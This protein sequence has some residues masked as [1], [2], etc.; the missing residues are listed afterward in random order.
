MTEGDH[1]VLIGS[2][3]ITAAFSMAAI[4]GDDADREEIGSLFIE[5]AEMMPSNKKTHVE[6]KEESFYKRALQ[7]AF[8]NVDDQDRA[9]PVVVGS[10]IIEAIKSLEDNSPVAPEQPLAPDTNSDEVR[11]LFLSKVVQ[12]GAKNPQIMK[13][14][15]DAF[16]NAK[17][18]SDDRSVNSSGSLQY[19]SDDSMELPFQEIDLPPQENV[20]EPSVVKTPAEDTPPFSNNHRNSQG[21]ISQD[22]SFEKNVNNSKDN[23]KSE[24]LEI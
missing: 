8:K 2:N 1:K 11:R 3:L 4:E 5:G 19:S 17:T 7:A 21:V 18:P 6:S 22:E 9:D 14:Y 20:D 10:L 23:F 24:R 15:M 13:K 16:L 12:G